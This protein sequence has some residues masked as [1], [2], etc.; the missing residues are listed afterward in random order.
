MRVSARLRPPSPTHSRRE[1]LAGALAGCLGAWRSAPHAAA[2]LPVTDH[3]PEDRG[4]TDWITSQSALSIQHLLRNVSPAAPI[5][6][7]VASVHIAPERLELARREAERPD[8]LI[9]F[10]GGSVIQKIQPRPGSVAAAAMGKPGEPDYS[11]HWVRDS[12]LVMRVLATLEAASAATEAAIYEQ[13]LADFIRFSRLLQQSG[14]PEGLGEVRYN[15]DGSQDILRW[16]R[17]QFDGAPLRALALM[18]FES[19]RRDELPAEL[20]HTLDE[21]LQTDLNYVAVNWEREGFDL[22]E[23]YRGHDFHARL[24]QMA[25]LEAG[26]RRARGRHDRERAQHSGAAAAALRA[27]LE[28][29]WL[30][31]REYYGFFVGPRVYWDGTQRTKPGD[32]F[33]TAVVLAAVH[34]RIP[35]GRYWLLD[36]RILAC[37]IHAEDLFASLYRINQARRAEEGVLLGRYA[38]DTYY[39]GNPMVFLTLEV[40]EGYY[41]IVERLAPRTSFAVTHLNRP[42]LERAW[43]RRGFS[44]VPGAGANAVGGAARRQALLRGLV[45]R[46]DDILRAVRRFTPASGELPEQFDQTSG[47]PASSPNLSWSHAA[48]LAASHARAGAVAAL[49][50]VSKT[51]QPEARAPSGPGGL[52]AGHSPRYLPPLGVLRRCRSSQR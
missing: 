42:F 25:A 16:S 21:V 8:G 37:A 40:A 33:D 51:G 2:S 38:G 32:N 3:L 41:G 29:H 47:S 43:L 35:D 48:F 9:R 12:A 50:A 31:E 45:L 7:T 18:H 19:L 10:T 5:E 1:F 26:A 24:V 4:L 28:R 23:E 22:W 13:R 52:R 14:S 15:L 27:A 44:G 6:R 11:F 46:G 17:P 39:G 36:D 30:A 34:G 20:S 49:A